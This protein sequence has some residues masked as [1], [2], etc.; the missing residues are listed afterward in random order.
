MKK[1]LLPLMLVS[2]LLI[3]SCGNN[4]D[5]NNGKNNP[6]TLKTVKAD[7]PV[8]NADSAYNFIKTQVDMG[9]RIPNSAAHK[10]CSDWL[11]AKLKSFG[12]VVV[13]QVVRLRAFDGTVLNSRNIIGSINPDAPGRIMLCSHWESR[14]W[15]DND[16]DSTKWKTPV[17]AANDGASGVGVLLELARQ[18][19]LRNPGIGVDIVLFDA[20]DYGEPMW[21]RGQYGDDTWGLGSQY[22]ARNPHKANYSARFGILLDMVAVPSGRFAKEGFSMQYAPDVVAKVWDAASRAG[23]SNYFVNAQGGTVNDDHLY[24]NKYAG[25]PTID[26]IHNDQ[27]TRSGFFE[28]WHTS[29]DN[30]DHID[31]STLKAVGQTLLTVIFEEAKPA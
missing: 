29:H 26:I 6:D 20:E 21:D 5:N 12:A 31:R 7:V 27:N 9:P 16:P 3:A 2:A 24:V 10:K 4:G 19:Q 23:Y 8:F 1:Y 18:L 13:S 15:S 30:M 25:I 28:Y 22:W 11:E 17:D 14:P